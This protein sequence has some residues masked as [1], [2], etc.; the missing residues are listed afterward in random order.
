M[1]ETAE[2]AIKDRAEM[3]RDELRRKLNP[4]RELSLALTKIDEAEMWAL[5]AS[6]D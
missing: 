5:R 2:Q 4:S 3:F 1:D 6:V